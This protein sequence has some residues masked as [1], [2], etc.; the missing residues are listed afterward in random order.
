[1]SV[2][3]NQTTGAESRRHAYGIAEYPH[4]TCVLTYRRVHVTWRTVHR[5]ISLSPSPPPS[6]LSSSPHRPIPT[7]PS[8]SPSARKREGSDP[9]RPEVSWSEEVSYLKRVVRRLSQ[10]RAR[11]TDSIIGV[12]IERKQKPQMLSAIESGM[13]VTT[14]ERSWKEHLAVSVCRVRE[15]P[16]PL[17]GASRHAWPPP[18]ST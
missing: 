8:T 10:S 2:A 13:H 15:S 14:C 16:V 11:P 17:A 1:M 9:V 12:I 3:R 18:A 4:L 7:Q 5:S 6:S